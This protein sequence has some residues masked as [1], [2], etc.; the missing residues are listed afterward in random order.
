MLGSL[1]KV[2]MLSALFVLN[3]DQVQSIF[4]KEKGQR[5]WRIENL[6]AIQDMKFIEN[7]NL[8][9][10]MSKDGLLTLFDT[11]NQKI[12]WKKQL[13][14][15]D[16][17]EE[18]Y[19]LRYLTR[20]LLVYSSQRALMINS[21]A[22]VIY[23]VHLEGEL[24]SG[25]PQESHLAVEMFEHGGHIYSVF[26]KD[27]QVIIYRDYQQMGTLEYTQE[28]SSTLPDIK[29]LSMLYDRQH[30]ELV[31]LANM[32]SNKLQS[33]VIDVNKQDMQLKHE[34]NFDGTVTRVLRS[35][36]HFI[37]HDDNKKTATVYKAH[38]MKVEQEVAGV[39]SIDVSVVN[40]I[41]LFNI[42]DGSSQVFDFNHDTK[43]QHK[44]SN[45]VGSCHVKLAH[46]SENIELITKPIENANF[47]I[48][49][50]ASL[51]VVSYKEN[52]ESNLFELTSLAPT[53]H[54][55]ILSVHKN[56][57]SHVLQFE[58]LSLHYL[59][60]SGKTMWTREES[61]TQITQIEVLEQEK[62]R[63]ESELE[64]VKNVKQSVSLHEVPMKIMNRY[65]ENIEFL[66]DQV[67]SLTKY[68]QNR[69]KE[70]QET[71]ISESLGVSFGFRK[72]F[73]ALTEVGKLLALSSTNGKVL[74]SNYL[75]SSDNQRPQKVLIRN[76]LDREVEQHSNK[77]Q[78]YNQQI[79]IIQKDK[80]SF[81]NPYTG[82]IDH[83]HT[84]SNEKQK[85]YI[86]IQLKSN[87]Q[88]VLQVTNQDLE[89]GKPLRI[90]PESQYSSQLFQNESI[91]FTHI[92]QEQ[93][94]IVGYKLQS[95]LTAQRLWQFKLDSQ[96]HEKIF[97]VETQF[98]TSSEIDHLHYQPTAFSGENIIYKYLDSNIFAVVTV[99][100]RQDLHIYLVNGVTG[101][102]VYNFFEKKVKLDLPLDLILSENQ[103]IMSF[104]RQSGNGLSQQEI[105]VTELYQQRSESDTKK[106]LL[107]FYKGE[108]RLHQHDFSSFTQES[109]VV[110]QETY[111][112]P[113]NVKSIV[114]T[115]TLHHITGKNLVVITHPG[116]QVYQ[117]SHNFF[118]ARRPHPENMALIGG[119]QETPDTKKDGPAVVQIKDAERPPYDAVIPVDQTK[120]LSY[121]L[122]LIDL[123]EIKAFPT[124][125][126][127]TTQVLAYGFDIFFTRVSPENNFDLLQENFSYALLFLFI[128]G[129]AVATMFIKGHVNKKTRN[130]NFLM[131]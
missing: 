84:L 130:A 65:K 113:Y 3:L 64:Y 126:E 110:M 58:D 34:F 109:P 96:T 18:N 63:I 94:I 9:Y 41:I 75:G 10:T 4:E 55:K 6:G 90:F 111:I 48:Q 95:D 116:N 50:P 77:D 68:L 19:K 46:E 59:D 5:D 38:D 24:R 107:E 26:A 17:N 81:L 25:V 66:I 83:S 11:D 42:Q 105:S 16:A 52:A 35:Y 119:I 127:S 40:D 27:Y 123:R 51:R 93:S 60:Q 47:V 45:N 56:E 22:H 33:F 1:T 125:L 12:H 101:R 30:H 97:R 131:Q 78:I 79:V 112:L 54:G 36:K 31:L 23:D 2:F 82:Q 72:M 39:Q 71:G 29:P 8:V 115:Q 74:W 62:I 73:I 57:N 85:D 49:C 129:L 108:E 13:P 86:L 32:G 21:A 106:L 69:G 14:K 37:I 53:N 80:L 7:S 61:L 120:Y 114:L 103:F 118:S 122:N 67:I 20:N 121:G 15:L 89:Q 102:V 92:N 128:A 88:F 91:H 43:Q 117:I 76:M 87:A 100:E 124:R 104:Q 99:N 70:Q 44:L 28:Q 98:Q